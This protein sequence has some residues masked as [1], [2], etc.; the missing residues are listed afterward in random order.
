VGTHQ[1]AQRAAAIIAGLNAARWRQ[2]F[3]WRFSGAGRRR[4]RSR[5]AGQTH[6]LYRYAGALAAAPECAATEQPALAA[7]ADSDAQRS[8]SGRRCRTAIAAAYPRYPAALGGRI[9]AGSL[10]RRLVGYRGA[11][12]VYRAAG[13]A[14][15]LAAF[16]RRAGEFLYLNA[17]AFGAI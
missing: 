15:R 14:G 7:D 4:Q 10:Y 2:R 16:P 13:A 9:A 1:L 5:T 3:L 12:L 6:G 8:V 17:D 11:Q